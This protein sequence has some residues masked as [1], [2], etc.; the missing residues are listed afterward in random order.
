MV[1]LNLIIRNHASCFIFFAWLV[2]RPMTEDRSFRIL[3]LL[4]DNKPNFFYTGKK[5]DIHIFK[6]RKLGI[7]GI[8]TI[9]PSDWEGWKP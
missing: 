8:T 2:G 7:I 9:N 5:A 3:I 1:F 4:V 6:F